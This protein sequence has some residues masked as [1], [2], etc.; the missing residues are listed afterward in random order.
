MKTH[1]QRFAAAAGFVMF[2]GTGALDSHPAVVVAWLSASIALLLAGRAF[3][4]QH[5][6]V[7]S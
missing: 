7:E 5:K 3:T 4:S 2:L 1:L 6:N